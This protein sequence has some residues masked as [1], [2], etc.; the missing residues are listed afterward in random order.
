M[1]DQPG[2]PL[3]APVQRV[4]RRASY[5]LVTWPPTL[6]VAG[7]D[8]GVVTNLQRLLDVSDDAVEEVASVNWLG[9]A[10]DERWSHDPRPEP[11]WRVC[12]IW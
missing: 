4:T 9:D 6:S 5:S 2:W 12:V 8:G 7:G 11:T 1:V 10:A 3:K